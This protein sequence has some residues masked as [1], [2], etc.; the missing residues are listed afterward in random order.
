METMIGFIAGYL[1]GA[2]DGPFGPDRVRKSLE[3][4]RTSPE[5]RR[6]A[7]EGTGAAGSV[8]RRASRRRLTSTIGEIL[9]LLA[10]EPAGSR[11]SS[12]R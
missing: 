6:L 7:A 12:T 11:S 3:A 8:L 2:K 4:I 5:L 10:P 1:V 9:K